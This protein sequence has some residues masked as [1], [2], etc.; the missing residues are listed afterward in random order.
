M[1]K[2][3]AQTSTVFGQ[4]D[5]ENA[6]KAA[7]MFKPWNGVEKS[8]ESGKVS[9]KFLFSTPHFPTVSTI[10]KIANKF[11]TFQDFVHS[12]VLRNECA[13][14]RVG[15]GLLEF[16]LFSTDPNTTTILPIPT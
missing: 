5:V 12:T 2:K 9:T 8:V 1:H 7:R 6:R 11:S 14:A 4:F 15:G 13:A 16:S 3:S 10:L